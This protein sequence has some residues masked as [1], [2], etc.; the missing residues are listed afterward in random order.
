[1]SAPQS[2]EK[3]CAPFEGIIT[4]RN[5]D[6]GALIAADANSPSKELFH[7]A[8]IHTLRVYVA[9]SEV[10]SRAAALGATASLSLDEFPGASFTGTLVRN[11]NAID[12]DSRTLLVEVDVDNSQGKLLPGAYTYVHLKLPST[13]RSVTVPS[14]TLLFRKEGPQIAVVHDS[15]AHLSPIVIGR[16]YGERIEILSGLK[17]NDQIIIDPSDSLVDGAA[18]RIA[19]ATHG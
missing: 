18:V 14:N 13:I 11:A 10:Y 2:Y 7:L 8:A 19:D 16:D 17:L 6:V 15:Q 12:V 5:T 3:V 1:M 9:V 4:A